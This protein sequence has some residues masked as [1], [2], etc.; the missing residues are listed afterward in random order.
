[1]I[2]AIVILFTSF[3]ATTIFQNNI[4]NINNSINSNNI[5][6][7]NK[8]IS[9]SIDNSD[10]NIDDNNNK[11]SSNCNSNQNMYSSF[12]QN[13]GYLGPVKEGK[14]YGEGHEK[15]KD[16]VIFKGNYVADKKHG[17][18]TYFYNEFEQK[19]EGIWE[20]DKKKGIGR[21]YYRNGDKVEKNWDLKN[22]DVIYYFKSGEIYR[23]G[24]VNSKRNGYGLFF[25]Q[26]G[27]KLYEG[28]WLNDKPHGTGILYYKN[29]SF[30]EGKFEYGK[31]VGKGIFTKKY[32][33]FSVE[34]HTKGETKF[35]KL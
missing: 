16:N 22:N 26:S 17:K 9:V 21:M 4:N 6:E 15:L 20:N 1:L 28:E 31:K 30:F 11:T 29:G 8:E 12:S 33:R 3:I 10:N 27:E 5:P 25:G 34:F 2:L 14:K 35:K 13:E 23:G 19:Y 7:Q 18:G 32:D 24:Y